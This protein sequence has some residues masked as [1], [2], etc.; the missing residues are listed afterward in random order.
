MYSI[1]ED[2]SLSGYDPHL[3]GQQTVYVRFH[4]FSTSYSV[5]VQKQNYTITYNT[6]GGSGS[7]SSQTKN[8]GV[9][10]T[11]SKSIP[12][13]FGYNFDGWATSKTASSATYQPGDR[14][15]T[16]ADTTL[17][18]VWKQPTMIS[19]SGEYLG[20]A[21]IRYPGV[22]VYYKFTPGVTTSYRIYGAEDVDNKIQLYNANG[23]LIDSD[24]DSGGNRQFQLDCVLTSGQVY[25]IYV[26]LYSS[27][28]T[29][30]FYFVLARGYSVTYNANGGN[31]APPI[32]YKYYGISM[33]LSST[34]P[35]RTG[36]TFLGWATTSSAVSATY[37]P[38]EAYTGYANITLYAV[39]KLKEYTI[40][41]DA[42]GGTGAPESQLKQHGISL[43]LSSVEPLRTGYRFVGWSASPNSTSIGYRAGD[44]FNVN[45][46]TT[47][48]AVWKLKEYS[49][50][51]NANGGSGAPSSQKKQHGNPL[52]VSMVEPIRTGYRFLGW[53]ITPTAV[54]QIYKP[55]D[56]FSADAD[57]VLYALWE[58][59]EYLIHYDSNGGS[60]APDDQITYH[61]VG[62]V[63]S[64]VRPVRTGYTFL[65]WALS[66][67]AEEADYQPSSIFYIDSDTV[68]YAV[69]VKNAIVVSRIDI[70]SA[71]KKTI[72]Q[73]GEHIDTTGL[74]I[75]VTYPDGSI[76]VISQ[77]FAIDNFS[78]AE[79]GT[80]MI[81]VSYGS[82]SAIF[83]VYIVP[84]NMDHVKI[85]QQ[86]EKNIT[87]TEGENGCL[88][89]VADREAS[90]QWF[91][92]L[93][94]MKG[95]AEATCSLSSLKAGLYQIHCEVTSNG[96]TIGSQLVQVVV[97]PANPSP[98]QMAKAYLI[99]H[100]GESTQLSVN[101]DSDALL[102]LI[103]WSV[104]SSAGDNIPQPVIA[105]DADGTVRAQQTGTAYAVASVTVD[106]ATY[107]A[108]CRID[109]TEEESAIA[110]SGVQLGTSAVTTELY[111][112]SY[113]QFDVILLLKQNMS[114]VM[115]SADQRSVENSG[116]AVVSARFENEAANQRFELVVKDDR[117]LLVVPR[118]SAIE[119]PSGVGKSYSSRIIVNVDG[120]EFVTQSK[121]TLTVK[122]TLPKLKAATLS[123][124]SFFTG[125]SQPIVITGATVTSIERN[126][127]RDT[128]K[129]SALPKW[130]TLSDGVLT[131]TDSAPT[132]MTSGSVY[133]LVQT[134]EW[135]VPVAV[136]VPVKVAYSAPSLKLS[137][138]SVTFASQGSSGVTLK[139]VCSKKNETLAGL[140][141]AG[142]RASEGFQVQNL[143]LS[144]GSFTLVPTGKIV[145]GTK[146]LTVS[147]HNTGKTMAFNL[148]VSTKPVTLTASPGTVT[149]NNVIGDSAV[150][151]LTP[152][153][154]DYVMTPLVYRLTDGKGTPTEQLDVALSDRTVTVTTNSS[155]KQNSTYKLYLSTAESKEVAVTIKTLG[156]NNSKPTLTAKVTGAIDLSFPESDALVTPAFRN[157]SGGQ[158]TLESWKVTSS[159]AGD[160]TGLFALSE[161]SGKYHLSAVGELA[162]EKT[163]Q[164]SMT[165]TL[166][167]G[168]TLSCAAKLPVKRTPV[169]LKL[170][171]TSLSL[172][173]AIGEQA[174]VGV[175]CLTEGYRFTA[176]VWS[177]MDKTGK[178]SA[179]GQLTLNYAGGRLTVGTNEST[180]YDTTYKVLLR[181]TENDAPVTLTV[182]IPAQNQSTV[183][184]ALRAAGSIDVIRDGTAVTIT[185]TYK[186]YI[187]ET[188]LRKEL[189]IYSSTDGRNYGTDVTD[190]FRI[191][192]ND[193]GTFTVTKAAG[194]QLSTT[195]KY[196]AVLSFP[197]TS[198]SKSAYIALAVK[199]GA[200]KV[201][202]SNPATLYRSDR[203]SRASFTI[204]AA[205]KTLNPAATVK[206]KDP[207]LAALYEIY[208]YGNGEFAIGFKDNTVKPGTGSKSI[209]LEMFLD[210]NATNKPNATATLKLTI[211]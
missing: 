11:L 196:R 206:I 107:S 146:V 143:D 151:R 89:V 128:A 77:G 145:S 149:L 191:T 60:G 87:L 41:Y 117:T 121:L 57:T 71:P 55:G 194:A 118:Q 205:D 25:Y 165:F 85:I 181:A 23:I 129:A 155:T 106:G 59:N 47:L 50:S 53:S 156:E 130:L 32:G 14:F 5:T 101:A 58:E 16:D 61:G 174:S 54:S 39:W 90:F 133:V 159:D 15:T 1:S 138:S 31:G 160:V 94:P 74:A 153:P 67:N 18:A 184:A 115:A 30:S 111:S 93:K 126:E 38:G 179:E 204:T 102:D 164:L 198:N 200:A 135:A 188:E 209:T 56:I 189:K 132:K 20:K 185:P 134:Q 79:I 46:D 109:V 114:S 48:Y 43:T 28:S 180:K 147:F 119:K 49:I 27:L 73:V 186:N 69:W 123:F 99:L 190:Q 193:S 176:P 75:R 203:F 76:E 26:Q 35:I 163:Y 141:V 96:I 192:A 17:Y 92:D 2:L 169:K 158:A 199:T 175:T 68:L 13:K 154:Q 91:V 72:Y 137:T 34:I 136:T 127:A 65:G 172:N 36:Y 178:N 64:E 211:K 177:V 37:Q 182:K 161:D 83:P 45:T 166:G 12:T 197:D 150:I 122:K 202:L 42:N 187:G 157:Y 140:N 81:T 116:V 95:A 195:L 6:N 120:T 201:T 183:T 208:S 97:K 103:H 4:Q 168:S 152:A 171:K 113:A 33:K 82:K 84:A 9:D 7:F 66:A 167:D 110:V 170:A 105:V 44:T 40:R 78:S 19:T 22:G 131:L 104:E 51:Y 125:Q 52:E 173:N 112:T 80:R 98:I 148:K 142:I 139:L 210:G 3:L 70:A 144:D 21:E 29:G 63:L 24:D 124:N 86:P 10:L 108:R 8:Q 62:L 88:S 207:K 162:T 100:I